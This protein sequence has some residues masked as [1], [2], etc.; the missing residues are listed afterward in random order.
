MIKTAI[1]IAIIAL[2]YLVFN[3][4]VNV[5]VNGEKYSF[6]VEQSKEK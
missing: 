6:E 2:I 1:G 5:K 3:G 4:G